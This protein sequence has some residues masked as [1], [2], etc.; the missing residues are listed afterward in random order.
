M[1]FYSVNDPLQ[2]NLTFKDSAQVRLTFK[3]D[4]NIFSEALGQIAYSSGFPTL[5]Y[6]PQ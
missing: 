3:I 1:N 5:S 2:V 4:F 6:S